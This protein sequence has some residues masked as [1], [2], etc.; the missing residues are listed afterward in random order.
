MKSLDVTKMNSAVAYLFNART[1]KPG[2]TTF[3]WEI[4]TGT[5]PCSLGETEI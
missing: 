4:N 5:W 1:V 3:A 2:E